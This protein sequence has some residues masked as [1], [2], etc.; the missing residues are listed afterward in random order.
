MNY[1]IIGQGLAGTVFAHHLLK[2]KKT[3]LVID[4][5]N[6]YTS[7]KVAAGMFNPISGKRMVLAWKTKELLLLAQNTYKEIENLLATNLYHK[8]NI[9][10]VF[11][12]V[13]EQNDLSIRMDDEKFSAYL[14]INPILDEGIKQ[15]LG[16]FEIK[17]SGWVN[18]K[19]MI[20]LFTQYLMQNKQLL[21]EQFDYSLLKNINN[22][23]HYKNTIADN[24]IF[25]EG[26][27][28]LHNPY[29]NWL[30][31]VLCKGEILVI[32]CKNIVQQKIIKKGIY[33][34][35]LGNNLYKVG[36]TYQWNDLNEEPS[37]KGKQFLVEKLNE[38]LHSEYKIV[39]H[40]AGIR[41]TTKDRKAMVGKH[42]KHVGMYII[43]GLG[44]KGTMLAPYLSNEI[45]EHIEYNKEIDDEINISRFI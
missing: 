15:D 22:K 36:A 26:Y 21:C 35:P 12:S 30:P 38:L 31:F 34:V 5:G 41:P 10:N 25:C 17:E 9:Y 16:A 11:A 43:N 20:D 33:I 27:K 42:P 44:T 29:F 8:Q 40:H 45:F 2:H 14:N 19:L 3:F 7:S 28:N 1:L 18:L 39:L 37:E 4:E 23:W 13:K 24:I 6:A 32:E